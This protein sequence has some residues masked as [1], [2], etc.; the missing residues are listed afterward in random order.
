MQIY[1]G[2]INLEEM[3]TGVRSNKPIDVDYIQ[4]LED[5]DTRTEFI[6]RKYLHPMSLKQLPIYFFH[7]RPSKIARC[8]EGLC[9]SHHLV[10]KEGTI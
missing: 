1:R 10:Y 6:H 8:N 9:R 4:A 5:L 3:R 7:P 2:R